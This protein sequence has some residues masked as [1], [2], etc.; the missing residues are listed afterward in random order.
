MDSGSRDREIQR[1]VLKGLVSSGHRLSSPSH[2]GVQ[3]TPAKSCTAEPGDDAGLHHESA[4]PPPVC[5]GCKPTAKTGLKS[6]QV[7]GNPSCQC[8]NPVFLPIN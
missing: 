4:S 1:Y 5:Q 7:P 2:T 3:S 6:H 8:H